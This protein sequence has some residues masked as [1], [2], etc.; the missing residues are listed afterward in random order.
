MK[1]INLEDVG[2]WR[3]AVRGRV[4]ATNGCFDLLHAGH[5]KYLT[6]ARSFG[7]LLIVGINSDES[8][9]ALKGPN[10]PVYTAA[11]RASILA[12]LEVVGVVAIF[13]STKATDFLRCARPD[14][15]VK[16]GDYTVETLDKDEL[17]VLRKLN[18]EIKFVDFLAGHSTTIT[19]GKL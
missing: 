18:A 7:D 6:E 3:S 2:T 10:R 19:L 1:L 11:D 16:G 4:V 8:V 9:R 5:V 14:V 12:A 17:A 13:N 15:Y